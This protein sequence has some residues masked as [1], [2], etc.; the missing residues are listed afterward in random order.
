MA[1]LYAPEALVTNLLK[2]WHFLYK[3]GFIEGFGHISA[4]IPDSDLHLL[5]RHSLGPRASAEDFLV[6]DK[7]GRK[8]SGDGTMPGE[9]P[10]HNEILNAR[11][12]IGCVIHYH[13]L[14]STAFTTSEHQLK[15]IHLMGTL[16]HDGIPVYDDPR[17][18]TSAERGTALAKALGPHRAVLMRA[19]GAAITGATVEECVGGA[20]LFEENARR[21]HT[22][23][24]MGKPVWID[25]QLAADAGGELLKS[26][27]P[28]K[29]VWSLV[30]SDSEELKQQ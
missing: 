28:F 24:S 27:G 22:A 19:H 7:L 26:R 6:V 16:F 10:I 11:P 18:V 25:D 20:F 29:R 3:R 17:L 2:A 12:D 1:T 21:A 23:A 9:Y 4:R 15:P 8:V 14:H 30:E 13:G 5:A